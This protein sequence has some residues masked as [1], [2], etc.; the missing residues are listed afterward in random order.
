MTGMVLW[1]EWQPVRVIWAAGVSLVCVWE[2]IDGQA[3]SRA[4]SGIRWGPCLCAWCGCKARQH[5]SQ[6]DV[7]R[8]AR[9]V[10]GAVLRKHWS[11]TLHRQAVR[12]SP[13][14]SSMAGGVWYSCLQHS[15][16]MRLIVSTPCSQVLRSA[17]CID[18]LTGVG[19]LLLVVTRLDGCTVY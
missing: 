10:L 5:G 3:A 6:I 18:L 9:T 11:F 19:V 13:T 2:A 16:A 1:W 15:W 17:R 12:V 7:S 8:V 4:V 14:C